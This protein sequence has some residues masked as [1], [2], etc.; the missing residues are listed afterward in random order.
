M[1]PCKPT[2][3][4][5]QNSMA[6]PPYLSK[7]GLMVAKAEAFI[8]GVLQLPGSCSKLLLQATCLILQLLFEA[9]HLPPQVLRRAHQLWGQQQC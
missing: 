6:G 4:V 9:G 3:R 1:N 7:Q 2:K 8:V 5:F